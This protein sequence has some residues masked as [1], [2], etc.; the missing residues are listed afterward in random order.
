M[1]KNILAIAILLSLVACIKN[2]E[3]ETSKVDSDEQAKS[4]VLPAA[5]QWSHIPTLFFNQYPFSLGATGKN[6]I[7]QVNGDTY[8][9]I[10]SLFEMAYIFNSSTK[11]WNF[12][13]DPDNQF[14]PFR[15][16]HQHLF[17]YQS[18]MYYG[19]RM[20]AGNSDTI[21]FASRD[22]ATGQH[23]TLPAFPG[24]P[25]LDPLRFVIGNKGYLIGGRSPVNGIPIN[26]FWE[27]NFT[28]NQWTNKGNSPI[29]NR[30][31]ATVFVAN[32]KA[33]LGLGY[34]LFTLNGQ[35]IKSYKKNWVE[36]DPIMNTTVNKKLF[37][38]AGREKATGFVLNNAIFIGNGNTTTNYYT[39]FWKYNPSSDTWSQQ[40]TWPG[41][42]GSNFSIN[43]FSQG[44]TG[45]LVKGSLYDCWQFSN[46]PFV[47]SN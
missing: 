36:Y 10:G 35:P 19:L 15:V 7:V 33:Y 31:G 21:Y 38:G 24:I 12:F 14:L 40:D 46:T 39:D 30:E 37:T 2:V 34:D 47:L 42:N 26:Q 9:L 22:I 29:G 41:T 11:K 27:F 45:F 44:N 3:I 6:M 8:C 4:L 13:S 1:K 23:T 28:T 17:S 32:N 18:K 25:V 43:S 5:Y 20:G 16:G